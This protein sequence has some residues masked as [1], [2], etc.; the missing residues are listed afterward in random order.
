MRDVKRASERY[1]SSPHQVPMKGWCLRCCGIIR[2]IILREER[3]S[4][5]VKEKGVNTNVNARRKTCECE[6]REVVSC[7]KTAHCENSHLALARFDYYMCIKGRLF[8]ETYHLCG[9]MITRCQNS[10][11]VRLIING[12]GV[13]FWQSSQDRS[14]TVRRCM[15]GGLINIRRFSQVCNVFQEGREEG[16]I[17]E[18][19]GLV[20]LVGQVTR[21]EPDFE[22]WHDGLAV[23]RFKTV[24]YQEWRFLRLLKIRELQEKPSNR[25]EKYP[26]Q[27]NQE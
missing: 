5:E 25:H 6:M 22:K 2:S 3:R 9:H 7:W 21:A 10:G 14:K 18:L 15:Q 19:V 8:D 13:P 27:Q 4:E 12:L 20:Y 26:S 17:V 11:K 24:K 16:S 23:W 1:A